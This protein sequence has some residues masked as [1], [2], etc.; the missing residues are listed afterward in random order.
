VI[1]FAT[2]NPALLPC[3]AE[4]QPTVVG[5]D[6]RVQLD[7]AW[8][9]IGYEFAIQGNLDPQVLF[10]TPETV[11]ARA[12]AI[13]E[14]AGE[15]PGYIFNLGHGVLPQTPVDNVLALIDAVHQR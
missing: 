2:G 1:S 3:L 8:R 5:V 15:R 4:A 14:M 13:L 12:H 9:T 11:R 6:W 7:E 10:A